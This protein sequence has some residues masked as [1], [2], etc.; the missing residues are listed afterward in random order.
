MPS[1]S[2]QGMQLL[3]PEDLE[4]IF[5]VA[6]ALQLHRDWV[7]I[8]IDAALEGHEYQQ[9]DGK[10]ILHAPVQSQFEPWLKNLRRR[11]QALDLGRVP[12]AYIDDPH[13]ASTGSHEIQLRGTRNYLGPLGIV[14]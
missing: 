4:R 6:D 7:I 8:P 12:R 2:N 14:R 11:L 9:P 3:S 1:A 5:R 13:L 10:I